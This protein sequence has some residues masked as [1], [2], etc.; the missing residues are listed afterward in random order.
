MKPVEFELIILTS[1][2]PQTY[3]L[4]RAVTGVDSELVQE[5]NETMYRS[6]RYLR[7]IIW[8]RVSG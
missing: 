4:E 7:L 8:S 6:I 1:E 2:R 3:D 5:V